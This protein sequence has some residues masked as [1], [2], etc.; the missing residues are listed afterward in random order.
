MGTT[1]TA[2][3]ECHLSNDRAQIDPA[4]GVPRA[5]AQVIHRCLALDAAGRFPSARELEA[6]LCEAQIAA[7]LREIGGELPPPDVDEDRRE[8]ISAAMTRPR[9]RARIVGAVS[10]G[11]VTGVLLSLGGSAVALERERSAD[12]FD[13]VGPKVAA[14]A[15]RRAP[16]RRWS[17]GPR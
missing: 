5:I 8:R 16:S 12:V 13:A 9:R 10:T 6:A 15:T 2:T 4:S 1:L 7:G 14:V 11:I 17:D 3:L